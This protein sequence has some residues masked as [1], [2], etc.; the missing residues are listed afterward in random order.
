[1]HDGETEGAV[2]MSERTIDELNELVD[3]L[4]MKNCEHYFVC[5][6]DEDYK[7]SSQIGCSVLCFFCGGKHSSLESFEGGWLKAMKLNKGCAF[8][9]TCKKNGKARLWV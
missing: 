5:K 7:A 3:G 4:V 6:K 1:M 2:G 8:E 9:K